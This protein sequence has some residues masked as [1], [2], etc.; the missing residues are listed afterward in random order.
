GG[1][2]STGYGGGVCQVSSTLYNAVEKADLKVKER[3]H[4]SLRVNYVPKGKDAATSTAGG[5]DFK[6]V[7]T[8]SYPIQING[9]IADNTIHVQIIAA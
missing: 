3:H 5:V 1:K 4:H 2:K 8:K 9:E 7:N 6:F